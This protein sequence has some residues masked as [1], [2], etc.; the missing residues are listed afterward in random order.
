MEHPP[1]SPDLAPYDF[2]LFTDIKDWLKGTTFAN[3]DNIFVWSGSCWTVSLTRSETMYLLDGR[4]SCGTVL[5]VAVNIRNKAASWNIIVISLNSSGWGISGRY[6][7]RCSN[8][9]PIRHFENRINCHIM[10]DGFTNTLRVSWNDKWL[11][12]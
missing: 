6:G 1:S 3:P 8:R 12:R 11:K 5:I 4:D 2:F 9:N 7:P 10:K